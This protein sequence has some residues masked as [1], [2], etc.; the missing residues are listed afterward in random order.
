MIGKYLL[1]LIIASIAFL[2]CSDDQPELFTLNQQLD[3]AEAE[4]ITLQLEN[5]PGHIN[6]QVME[7]SESRCPSDVVCVRF[8]EAMVK[9]GVSGVQEI[10]KTVDLCVGDC[11][12]RGGGVIVT[13]TVAVEIDNKNYSVILRDVV[14]Y[15][16]TTN[17][18]QTREAI[19]EVI[20]G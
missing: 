20:P 9:V 18:N 4:L 10:L 1:M 7:I 3:V 6:L 2:Q 13:D 19:L 11:P 5:D 15:P 12:Q 8:G 14:P 16:T 17:Q